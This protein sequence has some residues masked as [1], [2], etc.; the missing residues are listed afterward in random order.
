MSRCRRRKAWECGW[1]RAEREPRACLALV[2]HVQGGPACLYPQSSH[3]HDPIVDEYFFCVHSYHESL[4]RQTSAK[5]TR[6]SS[7]NT[8]ACLMIITWSEE[9]HP[10]TSTQ[11][12]RLITTALEST[13]LWRDTL[14]GWC[15]QECRLVGSCSLSLASCLPH[16][17]RRMFR[18]PLIRGHAAIH[19]YGLDAS[20]SDSDV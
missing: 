16:H 14:E 8:R 15:P 7:N 10:T 9:Q 11:V 4:S 13:T 17:R 18:N 5:W 12:A 1:P 3:L 20:S 19:A 2:V 6:I